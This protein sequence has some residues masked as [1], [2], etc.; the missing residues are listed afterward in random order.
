MTVPADP[1][2]VA[3]PPETVQVPAP[4]TMSIE[5]VIRVHTEAQQATQEPAA[6]PQTP[7]QPPVQAEVA[8]P[9]PAPVAEPP[10]APAVDP[11]VA[12]LLTSLTEKERQLEERLRQVDEAAKKHAPLAKYAEVERMLYEQDPVGALKAMGVSLEEVNKAVAQGRGVNPLRSVETRMAQQ[13]EQLKQAHEAQLQELQAERQQRLENEARIEISREVAARSPILASLPDGKAAQL[14]Y[15]A[16]QG[17][18][19]RTGQVP[20]YDQVIPS[21]ESQY[22]KFLEAAL[23][24][25]TVRRELKLAAPGN[26]EQVPAAEPPAP[27]PKTLT[28]KVASVVTQR[29]TTPELPQDREERIKA[30]IAMQG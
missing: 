8:P 14:V 21:V 27:A 10:R 17:H 18:Y 5:D 29:T 19:S 1:S 28:N 11:E 24:S 3:T 22:R 30:I 6:A 26:A 25:E 16:M 2:G 20:T 23:A 13:I 15:S 12:R 7:V 4:G 9:P